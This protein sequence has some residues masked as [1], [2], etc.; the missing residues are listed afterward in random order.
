MGMIE[1]SNRVK[2]SF[3]GGL[4]M[5]MLSFSL[6]D[7]TH[8]SVPEIWAMSNEQWGCFDKA[9]D[10]LLYRELFS[11][12]I[13]DPASKGST[14]IRFS[15]YFERETGSEYEMGHLAC[16][17]EVNK[18]L[19]DLFGKG[20]AERMCAS[21]DQSSIQFFVGH[22]LHEISALN[23]DK[24]LIFKKNSLLSVSQDAEGDLHLNI[25]F[26]FSHALDPMDAYSY[27]PFSV[28]LSADFLV[29]T[30]GVQLQS[31]SLEGEQADLQLAKKLLIGTRKQ[32]SLLERLQLSS[33][34]DATKNG[35]DML[36][37]LTVISPQAAVGL[38]K[39]IAMGAKVQVFKDLAGLSEVNMYKF[40]TIIGTFVSEGSLEALLN[41]GPEHFLER[42][43]LKDKISEIKSR[44]YQQLKLM[45][46]LCVEGEGFI[47]EGL[48]KMDV[49]S[50]R[51]LSH[52]ARFRR[53]SN[54]PL[55]G[56]VLD[57]LEKEAEQKEPV[58]MTPR[59][60][61]LSL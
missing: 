3:M 14:L 28:K 36:M 53:H 25:E 16:R 1:F 7:L 2:G 44:F 23:E 5:S 42:R 47:P 11:I 27:I 30:A 24:A 57:D 45:K 31:L 40:L 43:K 12:H 9:P 32:L 55:V 35:L 21:I 19:D 6:S 39:A 29:L 52:L 8:S 26:N 59:A 50:L 48:A 10:T 22:F 37:S 49:S 17:P 20:S 33:L 18:L 15:E 60:R 13:P 61:A 34:G 38:Y 51:Q 46:E 4:K 54:S 58:S 56:K 41:R